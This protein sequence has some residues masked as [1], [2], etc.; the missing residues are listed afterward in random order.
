VL[1]LVGTELRAAI[2]LCAVGAIC[3][4]GQLLRIAH[5]DAFP[6]ATVAGALLAVT[7]HNRNG[8]DFLQPILGWRW[9]SVILAIAFGLALS[10]ASAPGFV[11]DILL[12]ALV[13]SC[14]MREEHS[15]A[16]LL[17]LQPIA[18]V[19]SISYGIYLLHMLCKNTATRLLGGSRVA[20][21]GF[22]VFVVT[23]L[24]SIV[25]AAMSFK[26]YETFFLKLKSSYER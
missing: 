15:L 7:L 3:V 6:V 5:F 17:S 4:T 18:Y 2:V 20:A 10:V 24:M 21:V 13:G 22:D 19:G 16:P 8:F 25:A 9:S 23:L 1:H 26:Y 12:A 14:V 11:V